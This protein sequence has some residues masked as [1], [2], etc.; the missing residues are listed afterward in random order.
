M[1][2]IEE[3]DA[4]VPT[5]TSSRTPGW[6]ATSPDRYVSPAVQAQRDA[7]AG[8]LL[9]AEYPSVE[10]ARASS[11][12]LRR[13]LPK[14][15][16]DAR[17]MLS[18]HLERLDRGLAGSPVTPIEAAP[19]TVKPAEQASQSGFITEGE[20]LGNFISE[21]EATG[22]RPKTSTWERVK[23]DVGAMLGIKG[24]VTAGSIAQRG[25]DWL[26]KPTLDESN[27]SVFERGQKMTPP[28]KAEY[29]AA[30]PIR[31]RIGALPKPTLQSDRPTGAQVIARGAAGVVPQLSDM[32]TSTGK[33][34]LTLPIYAAG[35][36]YQRSQGVDSPTAAKLAMQNKDKL[37]PDEIFAP[38]RTIA[39]NLGGEV[40]AA[41]EKN[42]VAWVMGQIGEVVTSGG[43]AAA[44]KLNVPPEHFAAI[45]DEV[46]GL[47]GVHAFKPAVAKAIA[48]RLEQMTGVSGRPGTGGFGGFAEA[49]R[50]R[51]TPDMSAPQVKAIVDSALAGRGPLETIWPPE[52]PKVKTKAAKVTPMTEMA[53]TLTEESPYVEP[54]KAS[55][56][57]GE[58]GPEPVQGP[59]APERPAIPPRER[60]ILL[61]ALEKQQEGLLIDAQE[62]RVLRQSGLDAKT[63]A[64]LVTQALDQLREGKLISQEQAKAL[65]T[66]KV[67]V[68]RGVVKGPNGQTLFER[69][70]ADPAL[71][72]VLSVLGLGAAMAPQ[73]VDWWNNSGGLSG[74]NSTG[75]ALAGAGAAGA[76]KPKGGMWRRDAVTRLSNSLFPGARTDR[77]YYESIPES[78]RDQQAIDSLAATHRDIAWGD[79]AVSK[80]LN[81]Y[82]GTAA[83][84]IKDLKLPDGRRFEELTDLA[85]GT[86]SAEMASRTGMPELNE[87][88]A[89]SRVSPDEPIYKLGGDITAAQRGHGAGDVGSAVRHFTDYL[90][91][92]G[93]WVRAQ[94]FT[95]EQ[96]ARLDLPR[97]IRETVANDERIQKLAFEEYTKPNPE[98]IANND[99]LPTYKTYAPKQEGARQFSFKNDKS[100]TNS[101]TR[102]ITLKPEEITY[103]WKELS[104]PK[105][106]TPEQAKRVRPVTPERARS[107]YGIHN[108]RDSMYEALDDKG[109]V[110]KDNFSRNA[111]TDITPEGAYL[112]GELAREGNSMAHCVGRYCSQVLDGTS[113]IYS[114]RDQ[115]GRS[116]ATVEV[117]PAPFVDEVTRKRDFREKVLSHPRSKITQIY[118]PGN[119]APAKYVQPYIA[120]FVK[121][122]KWDNV[123]NL[124]HAGLVKDGNTYATAADLLKQWE[125]LPPE[126]QATGFVQE[127]MDWLRNG[128]LGGLDWPDQL[129][130]ARDMAGKADPKLLAGIAAGTAAALYLANNPIDD[131]TKAALALVGSVGV[132]KGRFADMPLP[133]VIKAYRESTGR[134]KE[135]AAAKIYEDTHRQLT[136][137][138]QQMVKDQ[139]LP[140]DDIVQET[141]MSA[142]KALDAGAYDGTRAALPTFLHAIAKNELR[143]MY[144]RPGEQTARRTGSLEVD[145]ETQ[146]A[147]VPEKY[148]MEQ[149]PE[150]YKSAYDEAAQTD[151]GREMIRAIEKLPEHQR[152]VVHAVELEG[153]SYAEA[154]E[155][156]GIPENTVRSQLSR[157]KES[158]RQTLSIYSDRQAG[159][160]NLELLLG[161]GGVAGGA[162]L[163]SALSSDAPTRNIVY[164]ALAGGVLATSA[165]RA[166]LKKVIKSPDFALGVVSTR[167]GN[168]AP[169][170]KFKQ[171]RHE[172]TVLKE[173]DKAN[174]A[175]LPFI[176]ALDKLPSQLKPE[177]NRAILN[178]APEGLANYPGL[179]TTYPAVQ[180]LLSH[181]ETELK[182]LGRFA[183]G[184]VNYFPRIIKDFD[185]LKA[186]LG[187]AAAEGLEKRLVEAEAKKLRKSG[188]GLTEVERSIVANQYLFAPDQTSFQP[189]FAKARGVREIP[190]HLLPF[191]ELPTESLLRYVSAATNDIATAKFFGKDLK[192]KG[193]GG[194]VFND[195]DSSIGNVTQ[196]L[197]QEGK[198]TQKQ[199]MEYREMLK[200]RFNGG[201]QG[202]NP[203]LAATRNITNA[204]LLGNV[205]ATATQLGDSLMVLRHAGFVPTLKSLVEHVIGHDRVTPK[206]LGIVNHVA[207]ELAS[208]GLTGALLQT[209]MKYSGF[210][211]LD[212]FAKGLLSNALL[213]KN[214][215]LVKT[216]KGEQQFRAKYQ[217]AF[218]N[219]D[220]VISDLKN[221]R[222]TEDTDFL[223][224]NDI[225]DYQPI[226][227]AEMTEAYLAHPNG[228]MLFQLKTYLVKQLDIVRRESYQEIATKTPS[229]VARGLKNLATLAAAYSV[230]SIPGDAIKDWLSGRD[231]DLFKTPDLLDNVLKTFGFNRYAMDK[232]SQ[233]KVVETAENM[234]TPPVSVIEDIAKLDTGSIRYIPGG[235][236]PVSDRFFGGNEMREISEARRANR[237]A[238]KEGGPKTP[239]SP[240][241]KQYL[242]EKRLEKKRKELEEKYK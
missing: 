54:P 195:V 219:I 116:Y 14:V 226:S 178:G 75:L 73:L 47:M 238:K 173:I 192:T 230:A 104:A 21:E 28:T 81:R 115:L 188:E 31:E 110:I 58:A 72:G 196:R 228:R 99:A 242:R 131:F 89:T 199:S 194:K 98:K 187:Q 141:Y 166:A 180:K 56:V 132:T 103:S 36:A 29:A 50:E 95:P 40:K 126:V 153:L 216:V 15:K 82:A 148:L 24:P 193:K 177:A 92:V 77:A 150:R 202:M 45:T 171:R 119:G 169:E 114:L 5:P 222:R 113:K 155:L 49:P 25:Y 83:D 41:Y 100:T 59:P 120:D 198:M 207:E 117:K 42:P 127:R 90:A 67:D 74:D 170:L 237:K 8:R 235:G 167:M 108:L 234:I 164:G 88:I 80:Y 32:L 60:P 52:P 157:A 26:T 143:Q 149:N 145:P 122:E 84:P 139:N 176:Q 214:E 189:G 182:A 184:V 69:G 239:L 107:E 62:A 76:M 23:E 39:E 111:A 33:Q 146:A 201:E 20:A 87:L 94:N 231:V 10:A 220:Q 241:A 68:E 44:N 66:L 223:A 213:A 3:N 125:Q 97:A 232:I 142:F 151:L 212:L 174:D 105:K 79:A 101:E 191:Y 112:A 236:K 183:E 210:Q 200:A 16:G 65:R 4:L 64:P 11:A 85:F 218:D 185:G 225:S 140:V 96:L 7:D 121:T 128:D 43:E 78:L 91:H 2:F 156:L 205:T 102:A 17:G 37:L 224:F 163:V 46:M 162:A 181:I 106:L 168:I 130:Y 144:R 133:E 186:A 35:Y 172:Y 70:K 51:V 206:D 124:D 229:G 152:A 203:A 209:T 18:G 38:W 211:K 55:R 137:S 175:V 1:A 161:L 154:G 22:I 197:L 86:T 109:N 240:A 179:A 48:A 30:A 138:V 208:Q 227:K 6:S 129:Q 57:P 204:A 217:G 215:A 61:A 134:S 13:E 165:G 233:G 71:L 12:A 159:K 53:R 158:M 93:D 147:V 34:V 9:V 136:R 63:T 135:L 221:R 27:S 190:E 123:A 160:V 19:R 118:G